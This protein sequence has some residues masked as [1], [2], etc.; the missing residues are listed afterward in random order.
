MVFSLDIKP[1]PSQE[2]MVYILAYP[3]Y[4]ITGMTVMDLFEV[5]GELTG[6]R[7]KE[8]QKFKGKEGENKK[9]KV[10]AMQIE[11][12]TEAQWKGRLFAL[13]KLLV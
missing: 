5:G 6:L 1:K 11:H 3:S 4:E 12:S 7:R 8:S 2:Q 10:L 9:H 13:L